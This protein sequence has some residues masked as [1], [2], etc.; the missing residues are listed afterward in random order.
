MKSKEKVY[1]FFRGAN[2]VDAKQHPSVGLVHRVRSRNGLCFTELIGESS[3][4]VRAQ[5][6]Y[7][8]FN[9]KA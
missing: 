4:F 1:N 5:K 2:S 7:G 3:Q 9:S 6:M 8:I